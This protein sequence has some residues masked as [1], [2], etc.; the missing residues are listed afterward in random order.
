[1]RQQHSYLAVSGRSSAARL[2]GLALA[3]LFA[4]APGP[5]QA[6]EGAVAIFR[7]TC[8]ACHTVGGGESAGPDLVSAA[9]MDR[10][11]LRENVVRMQDYA[12]ELTDSQIDGLIDLLSDPQAADRIGG[13]AEVAV[14]DDE[15]GRSGEEAGDPK[16][17]A[18]LFIG[19][20]ALTHGGLPCAACHRASG[21]S[22]T[23]GRRNARQE[24]RRRRRAARRAGIDGR[25]RERRLPADARRLSGPPGNPRG[26]ARPGRLPDGGRTVRSARTSRRPP[27]AAPMPG[28]FPLGA[29]AAGLAL[30]CLAVIGLAYRRRGL[31]PAGPRRRLLDAEAQE[32]GATIADA[33]VGAEEGS[34]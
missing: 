3:G 16:R 13:P 7:D 34:R 18:A 20:T 14:P 1:M 6:A 23:V 28:S 24:P 33:P 15:A 21:E 10:A 2:A 31:R 22:W 4:A 30:V 27:A 17:G 25:R 12:G 8:A 9:S 29:W 32:T 26:G 19:R 5:A 11:T